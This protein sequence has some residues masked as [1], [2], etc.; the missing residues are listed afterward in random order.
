MR[1]DKYRPWPRS[2]LTIIP[3]CRKLRVILRRH[4]FKHWRVLATLV[5]IDVDIERIRELQLKDFHTSWM[6]SHWHRRRI[7][8]CRA[9]VVELNHQ[10]RMSTVGKIDQGLG[11]TLFK[12]MVR[13]SRHKIVDLWTNSS[14]IMKGT[15]SW[16]RNVR[17]FRHLVVKASTSPFLGRWESTRELSSM[18][19][20]IVIVH[21]H[22][23]VL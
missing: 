4:V 8:I 13:C 9:G 2:L 20:H 21:E 23:P 18:P 12:W 15:R 14:V 22:L 16:V 17:A 5:S 1:C 6:Q 10:A 19:N 11:T 3:T 7:R